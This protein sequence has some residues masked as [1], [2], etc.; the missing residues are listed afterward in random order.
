MNIDTIYNYG[1]EKNYSY[2][3][4]PTGQKSLEATN[5]DIKDRFVGV[6][7]MQ[8]DPSYNVEDYFMEYDHWE[9]YCENKSYSKRPYKAV[10]NQT[11]KDYCN[12]LC[13]LNTEN[14]GEKFY[15]VAKRVRGELEILENYCTCLTCSAAW[16]NPLKYI[17]CPQ[18]TRCIKAGH[19]FVD[20]NYINKAKVLKESK[21]KQ[22]PIPVP[23]YIK[24]IS[25]VRIPEAAIIVA[26]A[27][28]SCYVCFF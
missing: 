15:V 4:I 20:Q 5:N 2:T 8:K 16:F 6:L 22:K 23:K 13:V 1:P 18:C 7:W 3:Q 9:E 27:L 26:V 10:Y 28:A 11:M 17:W 14:E 24:N 12:Y 25:W 21:E 19:G